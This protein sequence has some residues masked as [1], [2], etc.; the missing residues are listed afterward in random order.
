MYSHNS[1]TSK[2]IRRRQIAA[3]PNLRNNDLVAK[4]AVRIRSN[5]GFCLTMG[6]L[7]FYKARTF[8]VLDC[9]LFSYSG[10]QNVSTPECRRCCGKPLQEYFQI[11]ASVASYTSIID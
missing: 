11:A 4:F 8:V 9:I 3:G 2:T 7:G 6:I 10:A 1:V 5:K